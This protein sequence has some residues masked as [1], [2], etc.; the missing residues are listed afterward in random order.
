[1]A[2]QGIALLEIGAGQA[3]DLAALAGQNGYSWQFLSD[4]GGIL[5]VIVLQTAQ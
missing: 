4:A 5:R 1:L 3:A 2:A